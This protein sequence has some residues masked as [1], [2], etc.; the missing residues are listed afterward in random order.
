MKSR[1]SLFDYWVIRFAF[2]MICLSPILACE[3]ESAPEVGRIVT[4]EV[5]LVFDMFF[6][7]VTDADGRDVFDN[8]E[9]QS[10][11]VSIDYRFEEDGFYDMEESHVVTF[12][13]DGI[14]HIA[15]P[16]SYLSGE[17]IV[18]FGNGDQDTLT[19]GNIGAFGPPKAYLENRIIDFYYNDHLGASWDLDD[20]ERMNDIFT[21]NRSLEY[22]LNIE[23]FENPEIFHFI[24]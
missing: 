22:P 17:Y 24:K 8:A 7:T 19:V 2:E 1:H 15:F 6:F 5:A 3:E 12:E 10:S 21:R 23:S 14:T 11:A 20:E 16:M 9:Y 13:R 4:C 18:N